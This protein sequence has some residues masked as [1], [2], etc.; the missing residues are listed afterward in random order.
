MTTLAQLEPRL[1]GLNDSGQLVGINVTSTSNYGFLISGGTTQLI[2]P[3]G[4]QSEA[5]S[6]NNSGQIAGTYTTPSHLGN[7]GVTW[8]FIGD[9]INGYTTLPLA[10]AQFTI[11]NGL[12]DAGEVVGNYLDSSGR[13]HGFFATEPSYAV[14]PLNYPGA[15]FTIAN[16]I[17][18]AGTIV[19][20]FSND[21]GNDDST[22]FSTPMGSLRNLTYPVRNP[23]RPSS[24]RSTIPGSSW[25]AISR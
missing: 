15:N 17:N 3:F 9:P 14:T 18:N 10:G 11:A 7:P 1:T 2:A 21:G 12:N 19:G 5:N 4:D 20:L 25:A 8:G 23:V 24:A 22:A 16:G 13:Q 6:I